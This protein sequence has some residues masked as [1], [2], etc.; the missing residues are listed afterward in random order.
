MVPI[1]GYIQQH[2]CGVNVQV[3]FVIAII[4]LSLAP[5]GI[6]QYLAKYW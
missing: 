6:H 3:V 5:L 4:K 2:L 1:S